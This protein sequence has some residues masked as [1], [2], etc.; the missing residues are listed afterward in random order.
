MKFY[1]IICTL[2]QSD[3]TLSCPTPVHFIGSRAH[4]TEGNTECLYNGKKQTSR[5]VERDRVMDK[6]TADRER[7]RRS[8]VISGSGGV[9]ASALTNLFPSVNLYLVTRSP[10]KYSFS[11]FSCFFLSSIEY[12]YWV[13]SAASSW[14]LLQVSHPYFLLQYW[15][16]L[17]TSPPSGVCFLLCNL[18]GAGSR[19]LVHHSLSSANMLTQLQ[20]LFGFNRITHLLVSVLYYFLCSALGLLMISL[21]HLLY[22]SRMAI[23]HLEC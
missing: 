11:K 1:V 7:Q 9:T 8:Q 2:G 12:V 22:L 17:P 19:P 6:G 23:L 15:T 18:N 10:K 20:T 14:L 16:L 4:H 13:Q 3:L 5:E 21:I